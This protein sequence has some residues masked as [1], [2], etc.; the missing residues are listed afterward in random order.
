M[1]YPRTSQY[2]FQIFFYSSMDGMGIVACILYII[3]IYNDRFM[4]TTEAFIMMLQFYENIFAPSP[5][6]FME[7][8]LK[9][10]ILL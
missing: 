3:Y 7:Y 8:E 9:Q 4:M 10:Y 6:P 1:M 5:M 2:F